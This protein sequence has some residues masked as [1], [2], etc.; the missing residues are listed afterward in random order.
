[1]KECL[2]GIDS[3]G[4]NM[5]VGC[6]SKNG[7]RLFLTKRRNIPITTKEG[8]FYFDYEYQKKM[9]FDMLKEVINNGFNILSIG[10]GSC[11]EA[12]YPLDENGNIVDN[13]IAWSCRRTVEQA[14]E[15]T[16]KISER[17]VF[18]I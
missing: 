12:V 16:Q 13:A 11:G 1:M 7:R 18:E 8:H 15:F 5:K 10:T 2:V 3:C 4:T 17:E 9:I 6:F 14:Q